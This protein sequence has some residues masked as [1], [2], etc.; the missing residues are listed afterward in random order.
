M[1]NYPSAKLPLPVQVNKTGI[2]TTYRKLKTHGKKQNKEKQK[3][4]VGFFW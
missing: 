1:R 3:E 4:T 2:L